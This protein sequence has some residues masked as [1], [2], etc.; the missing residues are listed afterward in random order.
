ML[1]RWSRR[2]HTVFQVVFVHF[3]R[4]DWIIKSCFKSF[5]FLLYL[6]GFL[7]FLDGT[8]WEMTW[9]PISASNQSIWNVLLRL[10]TVRDYS[11]TFPLPPSYSRLRSACCYL[12]LSCIVSQSQILQQRFLR[13]ASRVNF[14]LPPTWIRLCSPDAKRRHCAPLVQVFPLKPMISCAKYDNMS[15]GGEAGWQDY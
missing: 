10:S 11:D 5:Y 13:N 15:D 12:V 6:I 9:I 3:E 14:K 8:G 2:G 7:V 4:I 1:C